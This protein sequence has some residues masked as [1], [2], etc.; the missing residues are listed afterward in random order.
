MGSFSRLWVVFLLFS[1]MLIFGID[2]GNISVASTTMMKDLHIN[3]A[4]MGIIF[5]SFFWSYMF[6]NIPAGML[7]DRFGP[8]KVYAIASF[9]WS[10]ATIFTGVVSSFVALISC[11]LGLGV[12]ESAVF[13]I[14]AKVANEYFPAE[15]RGTVMATAMAGYRLGLAACPMI[16]AAILVRWGWRMSFYLSGIASLV[17]VILWLLTFPTQKVKAGVTPKKMDRAV[18]LRLLSKRNTAAIVVIKFFCDYMAYLIVAWMPGYLVMERK[19]TILKMGV[20]ASLP[21]IVGM[22]VPPFIGMFSDYLV[23]RGHSKTFARKLPLVLCQVFAASIV[24][25]NWISSVTIVVWLLI[26]VVALECSFSAML[27]TV[28]PELARTGEAATL[29][30]IMNTAG[31]LAGI[32][33]PMITGFLVVATGSFTVAFIVAGAANILSAVFTLF[34]LGRIES[35][36]EPSG[37]SYEAAKA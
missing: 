4:V 5:S 33:S 35:E 27:W 9:L 10:V 22:I 23:A 7:A 30:G 25:L 32:L 14:N 16:I 18:V 15:R 29:A 6:C 28:P 31:S 24:T 2:R 12:G 34:F 17:W 21:W 3:A 1:G 20:Y 13:P 36:K 8:K 26:F 11:R 37:V 19:F